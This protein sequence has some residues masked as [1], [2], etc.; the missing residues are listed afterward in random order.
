MRV[1]DLKEECRG[2]LKQILQHPFIR[3]LEDDSLPFGKFQLYMKQDYLYL[4]A[5][6][7][8]IA[9]LIAKLDGE[10]AIRRYATI[11]HDTIT[12][13]LDYHKN[14]CERIGIQEETLRK[15]KPSPT[16][17]AYSNFLL[18]TAYAGTTTEIVTVLYACYWSYLKI[19]Q[20]MSPKHMRE[21][22]RAWI[23]TYTSTAYQELTHSLQV[24]LNERLENVRENEK[25]HIFS[26]FRQ[27]LRYEFLFWE[28]AFRQEAWPTDR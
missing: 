26:L 22:Y 27:S 7:Q 10:E 21:D 25:E 2:L 15:T 4:L 28:M 1:Q 19:A 5:F 13:E 24:D 8:M 3:K 23:E 20:A 18:Q 17:E 16:T 9:L 14:F 12:V 6:C 11:L